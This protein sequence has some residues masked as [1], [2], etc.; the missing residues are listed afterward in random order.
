MALNA[1]LSTSDQQ[2]DILA[3][4]KRLLWS[5]SQGLLEETELI[6]AKHNMFRPINEQFLGD[7][8]WLF[9]RGGVFCCVVAYNQTKILTFFVEK[10]GL[11]VDKILTNGIF[12][13]SMTYRGRWFKNDFNMVLYLFGKAREG[14]IREGIG[15]FG[16]MLDL[17]PNMG[18]FMT[19]NTD[20]ILNSI[21][22]STLSCAD[23]NV[24]DMVIDAIFFNFGLGFWEQCLEFNDDDNV[25][26]LGEDKNEDIFEGENTTKES[27]K[28]CYNESFST[29]P[30]V[31]LFFEQY[32]K[33][34][35]QYAYRHSYYSTLKHLVINYNFETTDEKYDQKDQNNAKNFELLKEIIQHSPLLSKQQL[36]YILTSSIEHFQDLEVLEF[37][38]GLNN[39][40]SVQECYDFFVQKKDENK[41]KNKDKRYNNFI[42]D[43]LSTKITFFKDKNEEE[44]ETKGKQNL[45][46][47][48]KIFSA[49]LQ[50][51]SGTFT[52]SRYYL[53]LH[54]KLGVPYDL[55]DIQALFDSHRCSFGGSNGEENSPN[56]T[57]FFNFVEKMIV[58][59]DEKND[60]MVINM[61]AI[62]DRFRYQWPISL[63][64]YENHGELPG[65]SIGI[66]PYNDRK[67]IWVD[68]FDREMKNNQIYSN[69]FQFHLFQ[70]DNNLISNFL[71]H[72]QHFLPILRNKNNKFYHFIFLLQSRPYETAELLSSRFDLIISLVINDVPISC[73]KSI[74]Y[75]PNL[76]SK[77]NFSFPDK[78]GKSGKSGKNIINPNAF[79]SVL[80]QSSTDYC[81]NSYNTNTTNNNN[82]NAVL[83]GFEQIHPNSDEESDDENVGFAGQNWNQNIGNVGNV[84]HIE[85]EI[86]NSI[87]DPIK[88]MNEYKWNVIMI[89]SYGLGSRYGIYAENNA[90]EYIEAI[91]EFFMDQI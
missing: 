34:M 57:S 4:K 58:K 47:F 66:D 29:S 19:Y 35:I 15:G 79:V 26:A 14:S 16:P 41:D 73:L 8:E 86:N 49:E 69:L 42:Y 32:L 23:V 24:L 89:C 85:N 76:F 25:I 77:K 18:D 75:N 48:A 74:L 5:C 36:G 28:Y 22:H 38:L 3:L 62:F 82:I 55:S 50:I 81:S 21:L 78:S 39:I 6:I 90:A 12:A 87:S 20:N 9:E 44:N 43:L 46:I 11:K 51:Q 1:D 88:P 64:L 71:D 53:D 17:G 27:T 7:E 2:N 91:V 40:V 33:L 70:N 52:L 80:T 65:L 59:K 54:D 56:Y 84:E 30:T 45:S 72:F 13:H 68:N 31:Q 67:H 83:L 10:M 60:K 37:F 61:G 63:W